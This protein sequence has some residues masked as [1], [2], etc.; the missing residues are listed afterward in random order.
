MG[1]IMKEI[2][3]D[4]PNV[5]ERWRAWWERDL[6]DR[7]LICVTAQRD[8]VSFPEI[9]V[10]DPETS[11]TDMDHMIHRTLERIRT[12]YFGGEATPL[13]KHRWAPG[14]TLLFGCKPHF[15]EDTVWMDPPPAEEDGYPVLTGWRGSPW[16]RWMRES[17]EALGRASRGR[18][19]VMPSWGN[20]NGDILSLVRGTEQLMMDIV[21]DP[22]WVKPAMQTIS[23]IMIEV[24]E[25][26]WAC[27]APQITKLEGYSSHPGCWSPT[28]SMCFACDMS[29]LISPEA[30]KEF[31]LPPML[32]T[33]HTVD[34][35]IYHLD[36]AGALQHLD[37]LLDLPEINAIQWVPGAGRRDLQQWIPLL[38]YIQGKGKGVCVKTKPQEVELLMRELEPEGLC[39]HTQCK[40]ETEARELVDLVARLSTRHIG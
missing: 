29:A 24:F 3:E 35:R 18:Y 1:D 32:E 4:W 17:T 15:R 10:V 6:Y 38:Q 19:Y 27:V 22:G 36:G 7:A 14:N 13:L 30:F 11:W 39:M 40:T 12:T 8:G 34:Y 37:T 25:E 2:V 5:K 33:M 16:W 9:P 20:D 21:L 28:R 26:L 31:F 23:D